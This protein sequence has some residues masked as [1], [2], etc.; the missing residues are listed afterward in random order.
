MKLSVSC[1]RWLLALAVGS[2]QW[3]WCTA[4]ESSSSSSTTASTTA[5]IPTISSLADLP[6]DSNG[7]L[8]S[9]VLAF[10]SRC[11]DAFDD[12]RMPSGIF[13]HQF[14]MLQGAAFHSVFGHLPPSTSD[15]DCM[16]ACLERGTPGQ[17]VARP[18]PHRYWRNGK[19]DQDGDG[20][21]MEDMSLLDFLYSDGCGKVE[22]GMVNY[23][24]RPVAV[25]WINDKTNAKVFNANLKPGERHTNFIKTFIGHTFE[26]YDTQPDENEPLNNQLLFKFT[27]KNNGVIGLANHKQPTLPKEHVAQ[28]VQRTLRSEWE[29]HSKV[30]RTFSPLGF[31]KGRLP[32]DLYASLGS[33]YYNNRHPPHVVHEEWGR[34][35]GV[36]VN[37]WETDV[38]FIQI[39]WAL[40]SRWQGRLKELVEAWTGVELETTDMYGMREY[41]EGARLVTHVDRESTHAASLIVNIAQDNVT[42]PWTIEVSEASV[43]SKRVRA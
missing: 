36:F 39:P 12:P 42:M 43:A 40:K 6:Y 20:S 33:Y 32:D 21:R 13:D 30:K 38:N 14:V 16:A 5:T 8:S 27:V 26:I 18:L 3:P 28:E 10:P 22:Y 17:V 23:H 24:E 4:E 41:T 11:F 25:Y 9:H 2:L 37:Y 7:H 15:K 1:C 31:D 35:K 34:H 29:R 19:V